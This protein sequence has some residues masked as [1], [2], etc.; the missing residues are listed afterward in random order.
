MTAVVLDVAPTARAWPVPVVL[1]LQE[2]RRIVLHPLA[3]LG[4]AATVAVHLSQGDNGPREAYDTVI[5][6]PTT[7]V[8]GRPDASTPTTRTRFQE[9][10]RRAR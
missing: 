9:L 10:L 7:G 8:S 6:A 4:A 3:L 5:G 1:G 2:G